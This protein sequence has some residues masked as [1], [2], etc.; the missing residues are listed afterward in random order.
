MKR[1][2]TSLDRVKIVLNGGIPDRVPVDLHNFMM[3]AQASG[4]AFPEYF[5]NGEAMAEG[6]IK[7]WQEFGHDVL[8][9]ENGTVALAEACG[10]EVEYLDDSAPVHLSRTQQLR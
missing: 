7:A 5:Q 6:H 4:M 9:L 8:L 1:K 2:L 3:T 10:C